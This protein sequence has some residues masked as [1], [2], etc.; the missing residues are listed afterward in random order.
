MPEELEP[1]EKAQPR[2]ILSPEGWACKDCFYAFLPHAGTIECRRF[3][4]APYFQPNGGVTNIRPRIG[5]FYW[6][7]EFKAAG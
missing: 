4:P 3:P 2:S 7:G 1:V 6:C 5:Q